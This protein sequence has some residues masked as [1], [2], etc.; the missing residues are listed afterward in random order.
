MTNLSELTTLRVGG[1]AERIIAPATTRELVESAL[2]VWASGDEWFVLGG[3][4]NVV[5][6]DEGFHGTVIRV[7]TRGI[8][9]SRDAGHVWASSALGRDLTAAVPPASAVISAIASE[10]APAAEVTATLARTAKQP[11]KVYLRVQAG[12]NWDELVA[13]TVENGWSGMEALSGIP[14]S[15]GA[16]PIQNIGAYGQEMADV[17]TAV[18]FL[19]Y[20]TGE[21]LRLPAGE[22]G[23]GYRTSVFK[24]GRR[25]IVLAVELELDDILGASA[26]IAYPQ[27][28]A[29]LSAEVGDRVRVSEVR[30]AVLALRASKGMVLDE[31]DADSWSAGSFFTNPIVSE[32][33]AR[34]LPP[35][36]PRWPLW[37]EPQDL[38]VPLGAEPASPPEHEERMVKLSAAWLIER[39]GISRGF[40]LTGSRAAISS[41]HT[42]AITNT[43]G[44]TAAE[45]LQLASFVQ[46]RVMSE[47]G[48]QLQPE[49]VVLA[50]PVEYHG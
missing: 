48:V 45:V 44:A 46:T 13:W 5:I 1:P 18:E 17:L 9:V 49:P 35:D 29:A 25:G 31:A 7:V 26:P 38:A 40:R 14:G 39:S 41:K 19:D 27:L 33:F 10:A 15:V 11:S 24:Q 28:A 6:A 37:D 42:L 16:A 3:G 4:S 32:E 30:D 20:E 50:P 43:G 21:V 2:E 22:L 8:E 47:F 36:A 34:A 23:F 12:Q